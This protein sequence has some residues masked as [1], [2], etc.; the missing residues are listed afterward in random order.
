MEIKHIGHL[1]ESPLTFDVP[2]NRTVISKG[3]KTS[4]CKKCHY[5]VLACCADGIKLPPML[6]LERKMCAGK[7]LAR[8]IQ[9]VHG[10]GRIDKNGMKL[11]TDKVWG[12]RKGP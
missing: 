10:N 1:D 12:R 2:S 3:E 8:V 4:D 5:T 6:I 11:W 7:I 9:H